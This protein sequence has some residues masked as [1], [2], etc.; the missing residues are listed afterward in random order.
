MST[1]KQAV[2]RRDRLDKSIRAFMPR[3]GSF[4]QLQYVELISVVRSVSTMLTPSK[5]RYERRDHPI[6]RV[7]Y[8]LSKMSC[9]WQDWLRP[10]YTWQPD[11]SQSNRLQFHSLVN[12]LFVKYEVPQFLMNCWFDDGR[13]IRLLVA[14]GRGSSVRKCR[15]PIKMSKSMARQFMCAPVDLTPM[16]GVRFAQV[17]SLG[18][19]DRL[20]RSVLQTRLSTIQNDE[21]FWQE[22]LLFA[23]RNEQGN[24]KSGVATSLTFDELESM[25]EFCHSQKFELA[26]RVVGYDVL[27]DRPLNP[28]LSPKG[29]SVRWLRQ[30]MANWRQEVEMP[31]WS[32]HAIDQ[33]RNHYYPTA[34]GIEGYKRTDG[35][36]DWSIKQIECSEELFFEGHF[37][38]HCV[39]SYNKR[40]ISGSTTIWSLKHHVDGKAKRLATIEVWPN[41]KTIVQA[42]GKLNSKPSVLAKRLIKEWAQMENLSFN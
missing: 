31:V 29:R 6:D 19:S 21:S 37:M 12:H 13:T 33:R 28:T 35:Q 1:Q 32:P 11:T 2:G 7:V 9:C 15:L 26:S 39:G 40:C 20:A 27:M 8:A 42:K 16:Q 3:S 36:S 25:V 18:G 10:V 24:V 41:S 30:R 34:E 17:K 22:F 23:A 4:M 5:V 14:L 38:Q